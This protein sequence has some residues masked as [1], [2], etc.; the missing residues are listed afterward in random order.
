MVGVAINS[1]TRK[2]ASLAP[3][4]AQVV[5]E[6]SRKLPINSMGIIEGYYRSDMIGP[7]SVKSVTYSRV[8]AEGQVSE[9]AAPD[10]ILVLD[11][12]AL[13]MAYCPLNYDEGFP[14]TD[15][16]TPFWERLDF[17]PI[18]AYTAF[19]QWLDQGQR[20]NR[21]V[22][23]LT[24]DMTLQQSLIYHRMSPED[25]AAYDAHN[26]KAYQHLSSSSNARGSSG[27]SG[28]LNVDTA[29][30]FEK[31][32][33]GEAERQRES[34]IREAKSHQESIR[35]NRRIHFRTQYINRWGMAPSD[36][37]V[38]EYAN[39]PLPE[40]DFLDLEVDSETL[41]S[42]RPISEF[43]GVGAHPDTADVK[44]EAPEQTSGAPQTPEQEASSLAL[45]GIRMPT[46]E[47]VKAQELKDWYWIYY[48]GSRPKAYDFF[49]YDSI[50]RSRDMRALALEDSHFK[51]GTLLVERALHYMGRTDENG[52]NLFVKELTPK[53]AIELMKLGTGIQRISLGLP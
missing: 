39:L 7:H 8:G 6:A 45:S 32:I 15:D 48:W 44:P 35:E 10:G 42:R 20:G 28:D 13:K 24:K 11:E 14:T 31:V 17:E 52:E 23:D 53:T 46:G 40:G 41:G 50:R 27:S 18:E 25:K 5:R 21:K 16:G 36:A 22:H 9:G 49:Y 51:L 47:P 38:E 33:T 12:N 2:A 4:H 37:E 29:R 26:Q 34:T 3:T 19:K 1:G 30:K 43:T